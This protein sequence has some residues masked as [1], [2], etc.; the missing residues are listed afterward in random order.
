MASSTCVGPKC[1]QV[2]G[3][4]EGVMWELW[5]A[6]DLLGF[7]SYGELTCLT[8]TSFLNLCVPDDYYTS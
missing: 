1:T 4:G 5:E 2:V 3:L 8:L 7:P 6:G